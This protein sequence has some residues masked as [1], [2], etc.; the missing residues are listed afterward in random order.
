MELM[1][2]I[3]LSTDRRMRCDT[4]VRAMVDAGEMR[5]GGRGEFEAFKFRRPLLTVLRRVRSKPW[6]LVWSACTTH[7]DSFSD[8]FG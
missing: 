2:V 4:N 1:T 3:L 6:F 8:R 5:V 7:L